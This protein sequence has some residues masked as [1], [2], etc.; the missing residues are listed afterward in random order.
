[1]VLAMA[2]ALLSCNKTTGTYVNSKE[3]D[4]RMELKGDGTFAI[5]E[6]GKTTATIGGTYKVDGTVITFTLPG[7]GRSAAGKLES[8]VLTDPDSVTWK[9]Q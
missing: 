6:K 3:P 5:Y 1:M 7:L 2:V 9:K 4:T 8:G